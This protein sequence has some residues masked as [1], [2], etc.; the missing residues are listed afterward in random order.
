[1]ESSPYYAVVTHL[2]LALLQVLVWE[3]ALPFIAYA[4]FVTVVCKRY[5]PSL[6]TNSLDF[7]QKFHESP[8]ILLKWTRV[9]SPSLSWVE[10]MDREADFI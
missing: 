1:M 7:L 10:L 3:R 4:R 5:P 6:K 8:P 2:N 9:K